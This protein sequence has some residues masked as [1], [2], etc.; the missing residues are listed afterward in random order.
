MDS[1]IV[2]VV[3]PDSEVPVAPVGDISAS[4][5][6]DADHVEPVAPVGD[7]SA[8]VVGDGASVI[9]KDSGIAADTSGIRNSAVVGDDTVGVQVAV[10]DDGAVVDDSA[11]GGDG[12]RRSC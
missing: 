12:E 11:G 8:R 7:D 3:G 2:L 6:G 10:V 9:I 1:A 5:V 4:H